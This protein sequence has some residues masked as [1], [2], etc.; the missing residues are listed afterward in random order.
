[1]ATL[2]TFTLDNG[3]Q[4]HASDASTICLPDGSTKTPAQVVEGD[5]VC[6]VVGA[7]A[8]VTSISTVEEA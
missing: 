1:M 8:A 3:A 2:Y 6:H 4:L 5:L 7:H